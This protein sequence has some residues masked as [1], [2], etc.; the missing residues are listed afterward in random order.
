MGGL[1]ET[2]TY[3]ARK[4]AGDAWLAASSFSFEGDQVSH[5]PQSIREVV[6]KADSFVHTQ[7]L[8]ESDLLLA[9]DYATHEAGFA[10]AQ[11][12]TGGS[13][14]LY[15]LDNTLPH[16]PRADP[17]K[18]HVLCKL[19]QPIPTGSP[20]CSATGFAGR[21]KLPEPIIWRHLPISLA[22]LAPISLTAIMRQRLGMT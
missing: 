6:R 14:A 5:E 17:K 7:D 9:S 10:A 13:A 3:A 1:S 21:Q 16:S 11:S 8:R 22:L 4:E 18:S 19:G 12:V 15:H 20:A 2:F